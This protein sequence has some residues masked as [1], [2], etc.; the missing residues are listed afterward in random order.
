MKL[1]LKR[2]GQWIGAE[3]PVRLRG[4]S[5]SGAG[6]ATG[7]SIDSRTIAPGELFFAVR[8]ERFDGHDFV[9]AALARGA[10]AAVVCKD[11]FASLPESVQQGDLLVVGDDPLLGLQRLAA[12]VRRHWG[13]R[14]IAITGSA[15]KTTTK[16]AIAAVLGARFR[17]L[18]SEGNLN[19]GFGLP[20]QLLRLEPEDEV[21][22]IEMGMSHAGEI[23]ALGKIAGPDWGVVTNVGWAHAENFPDG[24]SG[25]A[26]AKYELIEALPPD[27]VAFLN[28]GDH[29]VSQFGRDFSGKTIFYGSGPCAEPHAE[30]VVELGQE[31][32]RFCVM[33]GEES[34]TVRLAMMGRHNV[35]NAMAAI[36]VGLEA[37]IPLGECVAA[38]ETLTAGK[39]RGELR[40]IRGA[41]VIDDCYNSNP[42]A[43][44]SMIATL[45]SIPASRRIVVAGE[46]LELGRDSSELHRSC[47]EFA[48]QRGID[49]VV[50]VRGKAVHIVD[51]AEAAGA[52]AIFIELPEAAGE[53]L[54]SELRAGDAVLLKASRGVQLERALA[55]LSED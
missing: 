35:T 38:V 3:M 55:T 20:L 32:S 16:E 29:Y 9:E 49:I 39:K 14:L 46:M 40:K 25:I 52:K 51:G 41:T 44:K 30:D 27:G 12:A 6:L 10:G 53:W 47:G 48:A 11:K 43:L 1:S 24:I 33:A 50:G 45:V 7:Y 2:I 15:G 13:G 34:A 18:K 8:G 42:E 19:N 36:A 21:A 26:R 23:A 4:V 5:A 17:V 28:C 37:G 22:V 54:R 31:G